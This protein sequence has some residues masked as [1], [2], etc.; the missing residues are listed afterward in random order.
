MCVNQKNKGRK[1]IQVDLDHQIRI[2]E[3]EKIK[4]KQFLDVAE[5]KLKK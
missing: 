2:L 3:N 4:R 1:S 5:K